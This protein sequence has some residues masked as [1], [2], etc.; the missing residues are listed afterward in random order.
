MLPAGTTLR[1]RL[2]APLR[3]RML[4][5][6][7]QLAISGAEAERRAKAIDQ[8]RRALVREHF[9]KDWA[10]P[11]L[12]DLTVNVSHFSV[13]HC[14]EIVMEALYRRRNKAGE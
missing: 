1:V 7:K 6:T 13:E 9:D 10:D 5:M 8:E 14:A 11:T 3:N 2:V 12:Y 4:T